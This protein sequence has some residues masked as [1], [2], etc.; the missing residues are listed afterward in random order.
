M[1]QANVKFLQPEK[2]TTE[3]SSSSAEDDWKFWFKTFSDFI[4]ALPGSEN[5]LKKLHLLTAYLTAP[6]YKLIQ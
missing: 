3:P 4:N 6:L 2:L 1:A 5:A